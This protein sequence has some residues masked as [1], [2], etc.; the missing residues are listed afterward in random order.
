MLQAFQKNDRRI[1][2]IVQHENKGAAY[3]FQ[4]VL[5]QATGDY[6]MWAADDDW[7][8]TRFVEEA[9]AALEMDHEAVACWSDVL[10]HRESPVRCGGTDESVHGATSSV[11][12][13]AGKVRLMYEEST[14]MIGEMTL[15]RVVSGQFEYPQQI[16]SAL[17]SFFITCSDLP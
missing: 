5:Q 6:F 12:T 3:N 8:D 13:S 7:W 10:S 16:G 2:C 11:A 4:F 17:L 15:A 14:G 9:V 1:N